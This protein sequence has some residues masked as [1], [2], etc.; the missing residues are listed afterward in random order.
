M[1][2]LNIESENETSTTVFSNKN[3][4]VYQIWS[5]ITNTLLIWKTVNMNSTLTLKSLV[6]TCRNVFIITVYNMLILLK[7]KTS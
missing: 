1:L 7:V 4:W 2:C 3:G 6:G 5:H